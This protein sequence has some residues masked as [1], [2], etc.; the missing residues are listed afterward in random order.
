MTFK[1]LNNRIVV[2]PDPRQKESSLG[3]LIPDNKERPVS[4][5]VVVG[6]DDVKKGQ[7]VLFS[8]F[9]LDEVTLDGVNYALVS[10]KGVLGIYDK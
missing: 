4:G 6:N 2:F 9:G 7:R 1:P 8:L 5:V 3:I 10:E